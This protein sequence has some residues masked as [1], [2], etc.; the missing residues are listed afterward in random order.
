MAVPVREDL[1][2]TVADLG[3]RLSASK[4]RLLDQRRDH[5]KALARALP[6]PR[7]LL[8]MAS[9]RHDE[10]AQRLPRAL[11]KAC[12]VKE[13]GLARVA[14]RLA[15]GPIRQKIHFGTDNLQRISDRM[16]P[17]LDRKIENARGELVSAGRML[18]SLSHKRV[19]DRGFAL[20]TDKD[21]KAVKSAAT[22]AE[23]DDLSLT[24]S[25]GVIGVSVGKSASGKAPATNPST[26]PK[27]R[28]KKT[29]DNGSQGS[30]F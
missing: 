19:L 15:L 22:P 17:A 6:S 28:K 25:D 24:F 21:G 7:D 9:Q 30:L 4:V 8:G 10:L 3:R 13:A 2:A 27:P 23:G 29:P 11:S 16:P 14:G 1:V 20:V 5:V 12:T 26:K 18:E